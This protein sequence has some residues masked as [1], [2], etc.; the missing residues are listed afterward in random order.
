V[1]TVG[2]GGQIEVDNYAGGADVVV[3]VIG[4]FS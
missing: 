4:W 2:T 3:D 1:A